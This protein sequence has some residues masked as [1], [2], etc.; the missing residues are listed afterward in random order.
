MKLWKIPEKFRKNGFD[1]KLLQREKDIAIYELSSKGVVLGFEVHKVRKM[2]I[3]A[4]S[5]VDSE[6]VLRGYIFR[7]RLPSNENFGNFGWSFNGL[8]NAKILFNNLINKTR[9][10]FVVD[11]DEKLA[12]KYY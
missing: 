4:T 5:R 11:E 2:P 10:L 1:F 7:E 3:P 8:T 6:L 12:L 9:Q